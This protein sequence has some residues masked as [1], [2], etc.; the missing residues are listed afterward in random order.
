[1]NVCTMQVY[2]MIFFV[3]STFLLAHNVE[4]SSQSMPSSMSS[5]VGD[6]HLSPLPPLALYYF[7]S[8]DFPFCRK[9]LG[10]LAIDVCK[11]NVMYSLVWA[12]KIRFITYRISKGTYVS[13]EKKITANIP[14]YY[15]QIIMKHI[16]TS[17]KNFYLYFC[18]I[19]Q[20]QSMCCAG[21]LK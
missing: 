20:Q 18:R 21:V 17:K 4:R 9:M 19:L 7:N 13:D 6:S 10:Q 12:W 11:C 5:C 3:F 8:V 1:M 14:W 2:S 15:Q 16:H